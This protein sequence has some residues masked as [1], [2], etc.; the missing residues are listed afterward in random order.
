MANGSFAGG[1]GT[2]SN[3][4]LIEDALDLNAIRNGL[5]KSYKLIKDIDLNISPYNNGE[6]WTPIGSANPSFTGVFDGNGHIISNLFINKPT[7]EIVGLFGYVRPPAIIKNVG[8]VNI[9]VTG[10]RYVGGIV[11]YN[12]GGTIANCHSNGNISA[13]S[14]NVGGIIGYNTASANSIISNCYSTCN[15]ASVGSYAGGIAANND[16]RAIIRNCYFA[17]TITFEQNMYIGGIAGR[18]TDTDGSIV[19]NSYWD[20]EASGISTSAG[21]TGLTTVQMK[22]PSSFVDWDTQVLDNGVTKV[23]KLKEGEYPKLWFEK[24]PNK[25]LIM[26]DNQYYSIQNNILTLLGTPTDDTQKEELFN[27]YGVE[28]LKEALLTPDANGNKLIDS[29][30]DQFE[31]RMM[32][33]K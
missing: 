27:N 22:T 6:G 26:R 23:W 17:G 4:Y 19:S 2:T 16:Y 7:I 30:N 10:S 12:T 24:P 3:P 21:G 14:Y 5:G 1:D 18:N 33:A 25:Y 28:D 32:K 9:N 29:L 31:I 15:V 8:I 20:K 13:T 11:G